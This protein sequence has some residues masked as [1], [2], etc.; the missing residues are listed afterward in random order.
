MD[1]QQLSEEIW[2]YIFNQFGYGKIC[3]Y[4]GR[5]GI[6]YDAA[7]QNQEAIKNWN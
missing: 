1:Y 3:L 7:E 6:L 2:G 5:F 4:A